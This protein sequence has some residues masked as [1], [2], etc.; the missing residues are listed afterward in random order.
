M[1]LF[2]II[3]SL[4]LTLLTGSCRNDFDFSPSSG[5]LEFSKDTVYLDTVFT[6]IGSSTYNLKVYNRSNNNIVI[7]KIRLQRGDNS[8]Y[9]LMVDGM[10]GKEFQNVEILAKDSIF[11]FVETTID[12]NQ[13]ANQDNTYLYTDKIEFDSGSNYQKVELVTLVQDAIFLYPS[14]DNNGVYENLVIDGIDQPIYGFVLDENDPIN[15]NELIWT[16]QKPYVIYGYAAVPSTKTL[17]IQEGSRIHFHD[18]SGIIVAPNA[19]INAQG[20]IQN[21]IVLEG[22]R[23]EPQF[24]QTPGQWGGIWLNSNSNNNN[25]NN[26]IIKNATFGIMADLSEL[27]LNNVQ[28]Y[29]MSHFGI[30]ARSATIDGFNVVIN[31]CGQSALACTIGGSYSFVHSTI[32]NYWGGYRQFPSLLIDNTYQTLNGFV[33]MNASFENCIIF[34]KNNIELL[35]NK[36]ENSTFNYNFTNCMFRFIDLGNQFTNNPLYNFDDQN[37]Y[38]NCIIVHNSSLNH[39]VDFVDPEQNNLQILDT[40]DAANNA[41]SNFSH[42]SDILGNPRSGVTQ[43]IGAYNHIVP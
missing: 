8:N 34:G 22:D 24:S 41:N 29:N 18:S 10:S 32:A 33:P 21:P 11:I 39:K 13:F 2:F 35:F 31:K 40:S 28:I 26:T 25:I 5:N 6:N 20:T 27:N 37:I 14:R 1:R 19:S 23:L 4:I 42:T 12:Y 36:A 38:Q 43:D 17:Q 7:P 16:N 3:L 30:L 15:G 9:R